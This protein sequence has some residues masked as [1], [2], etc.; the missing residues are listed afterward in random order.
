MNKMS[1]TKKL[2]LA[3]GILFAVAILFLHGPVSAAISYP[4]A[5]TTQSMGVPSLWI[6]GSSRS[7]I[8]QF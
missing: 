6:N 2:F 3:I 1:C 8:R 7:I 5:Q 4:P